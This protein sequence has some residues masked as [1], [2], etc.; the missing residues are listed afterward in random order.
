[1]S[2]ETLSTLAIGLAIIGFG[3]RVYAS[4]RRDIDT[5]RS[6]TTERLT[7][8]ETET[9]ESLT[10]TRESLGETKERLSRI[11]ATLELLVRGLHIEIRGGSGGA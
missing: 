9:R 4:L 3:W 1:M 8:I 2:T 5:L 6:E 10:E 7:R 11:E